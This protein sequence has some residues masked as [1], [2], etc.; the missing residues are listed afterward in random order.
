MQKLTWPAYSDDLNL[1]EHAWDNMKRR[2]RPQIP[3]QSDM[4]GGDYGRAL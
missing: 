1:I 2:V 3:A 4:G